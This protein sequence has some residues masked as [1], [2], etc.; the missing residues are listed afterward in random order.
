MISAGDEVIILEP[1]YD[2]Y[3]PSILAFG[4]IP[5]PVALK[6]EDFSIDWD[7]LE[8]KISHKTRLVIINNPHNPSGYVFSPQDMENLQ[9]I[10][11]N[12][13]LLLLSDE[14]YEHLVYDDQSHLSVIRYAE[15]YARSFVTFSF[16]KVFHNTGWKM[17]YCIAPPNLM[18]AFRQI[19]EFNVF[20]VNRPVQHAFAKYLSKPDTYLSLSSFFQEKRD[21]FLRA[22]AGSKWKYVNT[23]GT[24]FQLLDYREISDLPD[25]EFAHYLCVK[26]GI[27]A[28]PLSPFYTE[29]YSGKYLRFCFAKEDSTLDKAIDLLKLV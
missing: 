21:Y 26:K 13:N 18:S 17:G 12:H 29:N 23:A 3:L 9:N 24:Y 8:G 27:S 25:M 2:S 19:H 7:K 10:I 16:G 14:V 6:T 15:L 20:S 4:G 11:V 22:L 5:V 1:A 28:I